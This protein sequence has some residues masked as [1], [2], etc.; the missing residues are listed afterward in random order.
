MSLTLVR[1]LF[2]VAVFATATGSAIS[3]TVYDA[4]EGKLPLSVGGGISIFDPYYAQGPAP[5]NTNEPGSGHGQMWGGTAWADVGLRFGAPWIHGF[6][7][8]GEYRSIFAGGN[9]GQVDLKETT[10]GGGLTYTVRRWRVVHPYGKFLGGVGSIDFAPELEP[11]GLI[12]AHD[13]RAGEIFGGGAE[14]R[15]TRHIWARAEYD[16]ETW[17]RLLGAA[18]LQPHGVTVGAMYHFARSWR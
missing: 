5:G 15:C 13:S 12:Y 2:L 8:E 1:R 11:S 7:V 3:Q 18:D 6:S 17:G 10:L 16:Y 14:V 9:A 4:S